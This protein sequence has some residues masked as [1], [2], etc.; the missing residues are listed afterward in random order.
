MSEQLDR[1][2]IMWSAF[3]ELWLDTEIQEYTLNSIALKMKQSDYS[4][5]ELKYLNSG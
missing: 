3:S 5:T 2:K 4:L 1:R